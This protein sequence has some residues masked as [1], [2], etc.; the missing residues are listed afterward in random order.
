LKISEL[1]VHDKLFLNWKAKFFKTIS[2]SYKKA[3]YFEDTYQLLHN[4]LDF[5]TKN[6]SDFAIESVK[7]VSSH[8]GI[9]T[10]FEKSSETYSESK[11]FEKSERLIKICELN[12]SKIYI[13]T[14]GG[15]ELYSKEKFK[16]NEIDLCFIKSSLH[17]YNQFNHEFVSGLS[18]IDVLMF[19]S[20][21]KVRDMLNMY[22]LE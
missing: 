6:I 7:Q 19:N 2:Q 22:T 9:K 12:N 8:I 13:N 17:P 3:T 5:P 4:V 20:K 18:I 21:E 15:K 16:E 14:E 11:E 10:N 1:R